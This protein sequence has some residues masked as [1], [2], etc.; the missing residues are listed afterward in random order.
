M[1]NNLG[2]VSHSLEVGRSVLA[3]RPRKHWKQ[4]G[5]YLTPHH[6]AHFMAQRLGPIQN[7][8][9]ILD[10]A[11]G[12]G[13]LICAV[14]ERLIKERQQPEVWIDGYEI[15]GELL[16]AASE[17]LQTAIDRA[18]QSGVRLHIKLHED[19]FILQNMAHIR[20]PIFHTGDQ[21]ESP[22]ISYQRIIANPPYFKL[23]RDDHRVK[24]AQGHL[25]GHTNIYSLFMALS[26]EL[27][28]EDGQACFIVPRSFC[29]GAYFSEFREKFLTDTITESVHLFESRQNNFDTSSVLQENVIISFRRRLDIDNP[30]RVRISTSSKGE[31]LHS[32]IRSRDIPLQHFIGRQNGSL[33]FRLPIAEY[34][35]QLLDIVDS[36]SGSLNQYGLN[37]STG[38]V[39]PFRSTEL[40]EGDLDTIANRQAVPLLWMQHITPQTISWPLSDF[41]KPQAIST[42]EEAK[43]LLVPL[44]NYVVLRRF[45]AKEEPRRI[46]AAPL[47][48]QEYDAYR[49]LG[50]ENH[51][52]Y[53][54]REQGRLTQEE[55]VGLSALLNSALI[56][57]YI[58]IMNGN[59]QVNA[60]ELR[61]LP[62]PPLELIRQIG[63]TILG[64]LNDEHIDIDRITF[65][66]LV[67]A[68]LLPQDFPLIRE[69]RIVMDKIQEAQDILKAL[70]LPSAQQNEISALTLLVLAQ[71]SEDIPWAKAKSKSL[72]IHDILIEIKERYGREYAENTR[73][74]IRRQVIHQLEQAAV[75]IRNPDD[76]SLPTNSPR[77]HYA[78]THEAVQALRAYATD[79]WL[80]AAEGFISSKGT[81]LEMYQREREQH[82]IPL[83]LPSGD[84]YHLSPGK[85]NELQVAIIE[86]FGPRFAGGANVLY[87]GDTENK[88]LIFY[89]ES[90]SELGVNFD[91]HDK[92]P[93]VV[94][95]D[96]VRNWLF[97]IEA[98]TSHG[99]ISPKRQLELEEM[100]SS[101]SAKLTYVTAFPDFA[102]FK[103]FLTDIAWETEVWLAEIPDHLIHFNGDRFLGPKE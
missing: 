20:Y 11:I 36:W 31:R 97:L 77:T 10:P 92:L 63:S 74:T 33:F 15:D 26:I 69:T 30:A 88:T 61:A 57:R 94:L 87:L 78:L 16:D 2:L 7:G 13:T 103:T 75:I 1:D 35:E 73:E 52:N 80:Q 42:R 44:S 68:G 18:A 89:Q 5:Q 101:C 99:P 82:R 53:I 23:N 22:S 4:N 58:R 41:S 25:K 54:Y 84:E 3:K 86:E 9:R 38:P 93:D 37:V 66:T 62:L 40:L 67:H 91:Q 21:L 28:S 17:T 45:S 55:A 81:L 71:L 12:T 14:A 50:L 72:R 100:F 49:W 24:A 96:Q 8:D 43:R 76:P 48:A 90:L 47:L 27:L 85:H 59:T 70:G 102:T 65:N 79:H 46:I 29:S 56:D 19:D 64:K 6:I 32:P 34:D 51:L 60:V 95:Y 39:V 83:R 98:V